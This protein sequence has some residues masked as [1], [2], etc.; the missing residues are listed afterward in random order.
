MNNSTA[1][2]F[3][4]N[5]LLDVLIVISLYALFILPFLSPYSYFPLPK[6]TAELSAIIAGMSFSIL[7]IFRA[8]NISISHT[9]IAALLFAVFLLLQIAILP[10]PFPGFNVIVIIEVLVTAMVS[11][12]ITSLIDGNADMQK[13]LI[14]QIAWAA[15]IG[16]TIQA[17]YGLL[18]YTG[19]AAN[20]TSLIFFSSKTDVFGNITQRNDYGDFISIG[21]FALAYL[22]FIR[23]ITLTVFIPYAFFILFIIVINGS[24]SSLVYFALVAIMTTIFVWHNR[25]NSAMKADNKQLILL[26]VG[27]IIGLLILEFWL[28]KILAVFTETQTNATHVTTAIGRIDDLSTVHRRV[29]EWYKN[30]ILFMHHPIIGIGWERYSHEGIYIMNTPRFMYIPINA[31]LYTHSHNTPLNIL[32]EGGIIGFSITILYGFLYS[33]YYMFKKFNNHSTLFLSFMTLTIFGQSCFQYPLWYTYFLIYFVMFLSASTPIF[34]ITNNNMIKGIWTIIFISFIGFSIIN[35]QVYNQIISYTAVPQD[36]DDYKHNVKQLEDITNNNFLWSLYAAEVLDFYI[37]PTTPNTNN[38]MSVQNQLHY[39]DKLANQL[40]YPGIIFKQ[41]ILH[42][43]VGD[44]TGALAY[45]NLLAH[46]YPYFKDTFAAQLQSIPLFSQEAA[47]IYNFKYTDKSIFA[48]R[49]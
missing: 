14:T 18:Q 49:H 46:A 32:A 44:N 25:N 39:V 42:K 13:Q 21:M 24:R 12:G 9:G 29:Y 33:L 30:I 31:A 38:T 27:L 28:P 48:N 1:N 43:L 23:R 22:Y 11:I 7:A 5:K 37:N 47:A 4:I 35:L 8:Q 16:V 15:L 34:K 45:A 40:P 2:K 26:I 36:L 6:F 41:I 3:L 20:F 17:I 10:L 19:V